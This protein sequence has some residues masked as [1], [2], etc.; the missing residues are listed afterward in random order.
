LVCGSYHMHHSCRNFIG[1][2]APYLPMIVALEKSWLVTC[3]DVTE[4]NSLLTLKYR[5]NWLESSTRFC[6]NSLVNV[7]G[8]ERS[9]KIWD[10]FSWLNDNKSSK[11][12]SPG[13]EQS[14]A[15]KRIDIFGEAKRFLY[16]CRREVVAHQ[17]VASGDRLSRAWFG[18]ANVLYS[19]ECTHLGHM[20][21]KVP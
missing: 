7:W 2:Y 13:T 16:Q 15:L 3:H 9:K 18:E 4:A 17:H 21:C 5:R 20:Q 14:S 19:V 11:Q 10:Q 8:T 6:R 12:E 1:R